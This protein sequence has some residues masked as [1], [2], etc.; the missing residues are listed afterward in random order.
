MGR[1]ALC[2]AAAGSEERRRIL[3]CHLPPFFPFPCTNTDDLTA[4]R[5]HRRPRDNLIRVLGSPEG[6]KLRE[7]GDFLAECVGAA[8]RRFGDDAGEQACVACVK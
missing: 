8:P 4:Q 1:S 3:V 2:A 5:P 7:A 6:A